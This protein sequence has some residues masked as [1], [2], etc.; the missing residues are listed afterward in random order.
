MKRQNYFPRPLGDQAGWLN[1]FASRLPAAAAA[2]GIPAGESAEVVADAL[3]CGFVLGQCVPTVR[4]FAKATSEAAAAVLSGAGESARAMPVF[5]QPALPAGVTARRPGALGR[6]FALVGRLKLQP[7][8]SESLGTDLGIVGRENAAENATPKFTLR[9][10]PGQGAEVVRLRFF[11]FGHTGVCMESRRGG[12]DWEPLA[13]DTESPYDD[14][15]P[16]LAADTPE[17]REYRMRF[18][19]KGTPN[20]EWTGVA[21]MTVSP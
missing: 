1:H 3:W 4:A 12:G 15:R 10:L 8:Y 13:V 19:D 17:L 20:G 18:W 7:G 5:T 9:T 16:L 21:K 6:I 14:E 2:L 11:K